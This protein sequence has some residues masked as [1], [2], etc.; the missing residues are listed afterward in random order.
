[1]YSVYVYYNTKKCILKNQVKKKIK[2][3]KTNFPSYLKILVLEK[4]K[5]MHAFNVLSFF[6]H[7]PENSREF[8]S[9]RDFKV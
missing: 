2:I 5:S 4:S 9:I 6:A 1:M 3:K 8:P 7:S